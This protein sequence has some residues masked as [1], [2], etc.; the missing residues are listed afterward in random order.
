MMVKDKASK[1]AIQ[2][3]DDLIVLGLVAVV[4]V[5]KIDQIQDKQWI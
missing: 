4:E 3:R 2:E 1:E 5:V